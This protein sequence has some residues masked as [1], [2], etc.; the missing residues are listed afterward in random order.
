ME[1]KYAPISEQQLGAAEGTPTQNKVVD[2]DL[3]SSSNDSF[4]RISLALD[5][6]GSNAIQDHN[7]SMHRA[8]SHA[9]KRN[10]PQP[11]AA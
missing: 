5:E 3:P 4:L 11:A 10:L 9:I 8:A 7:R 2:N 6:Y 1:C